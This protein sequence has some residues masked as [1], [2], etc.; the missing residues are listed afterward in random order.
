M[1]CPPSAL[2]TFRDFVRAG[3]GG[4][5]D[6]SRDVFSSENRSNGKRHRGEEHDPEQTVDGQW[7]LLLS[8]N[9]KVIS[10]GRDFFITTLITFPNVNLS[11]AMCCILRAKVSI[12][13]ISLD[14]EYGTSIS[15]EKKEMPPFLSI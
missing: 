11:I 9:F 7:K 1:R 13:I 4:K 12:T 14:E 15:A 6:K 8:L 5:H 2:R 10:F 3:A